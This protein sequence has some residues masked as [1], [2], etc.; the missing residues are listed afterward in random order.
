MH[1]RVAFVEDDVAGLDRELA[2]VRHRVA[3]IQRQIEHGRRELTGIDQRG[4]RILGQ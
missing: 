2:A 4:P 1:V 3:R